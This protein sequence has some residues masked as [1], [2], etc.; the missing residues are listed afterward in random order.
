VRKK[1]GGRE[2]HQIIAGNGFENANIS[3]GWKR[4]R[5]TS[6]FQLKRMRISKS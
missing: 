4:T 5:Q 2:H 1:E 3:R 6:K